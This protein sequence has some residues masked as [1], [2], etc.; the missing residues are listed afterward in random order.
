M[1]AY[2]FAQ[3]RTIYLLKGIYTFMN[4]AREGWTKI[5]QRTLT[6]NKV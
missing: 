3:T 1:F 6:A 4:N 2:F 5:I